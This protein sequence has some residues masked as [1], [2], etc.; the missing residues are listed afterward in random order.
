M[1]TA[2]DI[3][4][5]YI[6]KYAFIYLLQFLGIPAKRLSFMSM[7]SVNLLKLTPLTKNKTPLGVLSQLCLLNST[8]DNLNIYINTKLQYRLNSNN[9]YVDI[10]FRNVPFCRSGDILLLKTL[11]NS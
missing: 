10:M 11:N 5:K 9:L 4:P 1:R 8:F 6:I 2:E 7:K 3:Y